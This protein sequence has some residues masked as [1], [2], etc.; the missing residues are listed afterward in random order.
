MEKNGKECGSAQADINSVE[1]N[2]TEIVLRDLWQSSESKGAKGSKRIEIFELPPRAK[3]RARKRMSGCF[4]PCHPAV[5]TG[6]EGGRDADYWREDGRML[7]GY[8]PI[9]LLHSLE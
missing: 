8:T 7:A 3:R 6:F 5:S 4:A 1:K 9:R 2:T